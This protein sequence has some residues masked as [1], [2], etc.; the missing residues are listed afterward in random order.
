VKILH[1]SNYDT[2]GGAGIAAYR[3]HVA[4]R[5]AGV[6]S[7]ML[8]RRKGSNDPT[9]EEVGSF[10]PG[11]GCLLPMA[12]SKKKKPQQPIIQQLNNCRIRFMVRARGW[13]GAKMTRL[14]S[15]EGCSLNIFPTGLH[16]VLNASDVDVIH[17]HW[18]NNEMI[19]IKEIA[20]INKPLVWTLHDC[21]PF[22]GAEHHSFANYWRRS[23]NRDQKIENSEQPIAT[24]NQQPATSTA[25]YDMVNQW[26]F[27]KKRRLWNRLNVSFI[28][29]SHWM[30]KQVRQSRLFRAA[31]VT[32]ISN[33][34]DLDVFK[35]MDRAECR[36]RSGL[37][38]DKKLILFG[39]Y[40]P[41]DSNKGSDLLEWALA[42]FPEGIWKNT[43]LAVFGAEG[44]KDVA[45]L[46]THWLGI[47]SSEKKLAELYNTADIFVCPSRKETLPTTIA[48]ALAC[49]VPCVGFNIGGIPDMIVHQQ[50]GW[51][52]EPY[53]PKDFCDGIEWVMGGKT[54]LEQEE[55]SQNA[56]TKGK[57]MF[58]EKAVVQ[59]HVVLYETRLRLCIEK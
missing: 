39:A 57:C 14:L 22:L 36:Q 27:Q 23:E 32:V 33:C 48:E 56:R 37:P 59:R 42:E 24:D 2:L 7:W 44:E 10:D 16:K 52:A 34:L 18:I 11:E 53:D 4:L 13:L 19:S 3:L 45:G 8:V 49:G 54:A 31:P 58:A 17:L 5:K 26:I 21:W 9:V 29:P 46:T 35:P 30:A 43:E 40:N 47:I 41:R 20:K 28:A 1:I 25:L 12:G 6:D 15:M 51:L 38:K 55:R 50:N